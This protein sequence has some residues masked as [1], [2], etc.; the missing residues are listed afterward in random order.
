MNTCKIKDYNEKL[1]RLRAYMSGKGFGHV[2][3]ARRDNFA[4]L[5]GG[6]DNKIFRSSDIGFGILVVSQDRVTF[7]AQ[8]MDMARIRDDELNGFDMETITLR[9]QDPSREETALAIC[10]GMRTAGDF[11]LKGAENVQGELVRLHFPLTD[12]DMERYAE[13]AGLFDRLLKNVADRIRPGMTE[14]EIEADILYEYAKECATPK[15]LLVGSDER[16][17]KY[18]HPNASDKK[19]EKLVL[20]H[21]AAEKW[22]L[23]ANITR[24]VYFG[25][26]LPEELDRKYE[27]LNRI[28]AQTVS[29]LRPGVRYHEILDERKKIF[30]AYGCEDEFM[31]HYPGATAGYFIGS[32]Q[33]I[34]DNEEIMDRMVYDWF[35][36]VAGAKVEELSVSGHDGGKVLSAAGAWPLKEYAWQG[37]TY[38]LPVIL[39]K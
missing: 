18:R 6:G 1:G 32:A 23:H 26:K 38:K 2:I 31:N 8:Y 37:K 29:M 20:M 19:V 13:V 5:T 9:W 17:A 33:P 7:I 22:G 28:Q 24:M 35:I 4:W 27:L 15:V 12:Y 36:T 11:D 39:L 25:D 21:P 16:I 14:H 34:I 10:K 3:L 30:A